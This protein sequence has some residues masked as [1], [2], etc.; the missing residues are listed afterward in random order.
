MAYT[1]SITP[2]RGRGAAKNGRP[3]GKERP[4]ASGRGDGGLGDAA[5]LRWEDRD[6]G[7]GRQE[8]GA[9]AP[10]RRMAAR[11]SGR[12]A[13]G[14]GWGS[15]GERGPWGPKRHPSPASPQLTEHED[16]TVAHHGGAM[17]S[18]APKTGV[19]GR[20]FWREN[21]REDQKTLPP[22]GLHLN[23]LPSGPPPISA[24]SSLTGTEAD[25]WA[26]LAPP[27]RKNGRASSV[28][29]ARRWTWEGAGACAI[30]RPLPAA[31]GANHGASAETRAVG[32]RAS[33]HACQQR[34][35]MPGLRLSQHRRWAPCAGLRLGSSQAVKVKKGVTVSPF[36][37]PLSNGEE[38]RGGTASP[39]GETWRRGCGG[40]RELW[41]ITRALA[42]VRG[43]PPSQAC[44]SCRGPERCQRVAACFTPELSCLNIFSKV[45]RRVCGFFFFPRPL[46]PLRSSAQ[47][48]VG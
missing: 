46:P 18:P 25:Q 9:A 7:E 21:L 44:A 36:W 39:E 3:G 35:R 19:T 12:A 48:P 4:E 34:W 14:L 45:P 37:F 40:S 24:P 30:A 17:Q 10:G 15:P 26:L 43:P 47:L 16:G 2:G 13:A 32:R 11:L 38:W 41:F 6:R 33:A 20:S 1:L 27:L 8:S 29:R 5:R 31:C 23:P 22:Q 42:A 28:E